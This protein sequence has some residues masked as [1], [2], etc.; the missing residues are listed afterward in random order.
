M[1]QEPR[2]SNDGLLMRD[3]LLL[4]AGPTGL[5][6]IFTIDAIKRGHSVA[7]MTPTASKLADDFNVFRLDRERLAD[8]EN[9]MLRANKSI[10][11][12]WPLNDDTTNDNLRRDCY[13]V[14]WC[15]RIYS[16]G[17]F[18]SDAS[19]LK[20]AGD[21]AWPAQIYVDRFLYDQEPMSQCELYMFDLKS[22][23]WFQWNQ[24]WMKANEVPR[25]S[26]IYTVVG[27]DKLSRAAKIAIDYLWI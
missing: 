21:L 25:P 11:R 13:L 27:S 15:Q 22:E 2:D 19:L 17:L 5:S 20:I 26:G 9:Y 16:V 24:R 18:T 1:Q 23:S 7:Y 10:H 12:S 8:A 6:G 4:G 14:R 3:D